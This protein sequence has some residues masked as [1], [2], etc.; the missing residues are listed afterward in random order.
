M[1][2]R[3]FAAVP[4]LFAATLALANAALPPFIYPLPDY[5]DRVTGSFGEFRTGHLHGGI[6][7]GTMLKVGLPVLAADSGYVAS[8]ASSD[9]GYGRSILI[10]HPSGFSTFYAHLDDFSPSIK[11]HLPAEPVFRMDFLPGEIPV[12]AAETIALSGESGSGFPHL[13]FE[14]RFAGRT[15][16]PLQFNIGPPDLSPPV[17]LRLYLIPADHLSGVPYIVSLRN[18]R[19]ESPKS[20]HLPITGRFWVELDAYDPG[21]GSARLVPSRVRAEAGLY[22]YSLD[23]DSLEPPTDRRVYEVYNPAA[24]H[25]SP[26]FFTFRL[27]DLGS[28]RC[29]PVWNSEES[30][31]I[32]LADPAGNTSD[33]RVSAGAGTDSDTASAPMPDIRYEDVLQSPAFSGPLSPP[34]FALPSG[35][36]LA[37]TV[38][39]AFTLL[40]ARETVLHGTGAFPRDGAIISL[41]SYAFPAAGRLEVGGV[42]GTGLAAA[43]WDIVAGSASPERAYAF[44]LASLSFSLPAGALRRP[45]TLAAVASHPPFVPAGLRALSDAVFLSPFGEPLALPV[46]METAGSTPVTTKS[47]IYRLDSFSQ[48]WKVVPFVR[49]NNTVSWDAPYLATFAVLEDESPPEVRD[50]Y[51]YRDRL[52]IPVKDIGLGVDSSSIRVTYAGKPVVGEWDPDWRHFL[53]TIPAARISRKANLRVHL[54]DHAGNPASRAFLRPIQV[55]TG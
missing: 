17:M 22:C 24:T 49:T 13:H 25:L 36:Y 30:L 28:S 41:E 23:L 7:I 45:V 51:I 32:T 43:R 29:S 48:S 52:A 31:H 33:L 15:L 35:L 38:S 6:D 54:R 55:S 16:N 12:Q 1:P 47:G 26:T 42:S 37:G 8:V 40:L 46:R 21:A 14:I 27:Y 44:S 11:S 10:R 5:P 20:L 9:S 18:E 39:P 4:A 19:G 3:R 50:L 53:T 34:V 2:G